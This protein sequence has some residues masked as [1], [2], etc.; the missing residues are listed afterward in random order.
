M[1]TTESPMPEARPH[2][3][4]DGLHRL[5]GTWRLSGEAQGTIEY[6]WAEGGFF[7]LQ[8]VDIVHDGK[9]ISGIEIIGRQYRL[10]GEPSAEIASRFYSYLDGLTL[11]YTYELWD[12][13]LTIWFGDRESSHYY[14][15]VISPDGNTMVGAWQ[16]PGGGYRV[17]AKRSR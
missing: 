13:T 2:P 15:A 9:R 14:R 12:D 17:T 10:V 16:W 5:V 11:D 6:E 7:L 4:L 1:T 3:D 8:H